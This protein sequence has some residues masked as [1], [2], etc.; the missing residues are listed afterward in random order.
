MTNLKVL[1]AFIFAQQRFVSSF[2]IQKI[3]RS[4]HLRAMVLTIEYIS[5]ALSDVS[6]VGG[7]VV[8]NGGVE[9]LGRTVGRLTLPTHTP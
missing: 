2:F 5:W 1:F 6:P 3:S 7:S 8:P 9:L 4:A